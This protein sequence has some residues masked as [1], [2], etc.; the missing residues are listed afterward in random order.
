MVQEQ[1]LSKANW[2]YYC[3][4][5]RRESTTSFQSRW[6]LE[7]DPPN[8]PLFYVPQRKRP[9]FHELLGPTDRRSYQEW[10]DEPNQM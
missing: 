4:D 8:P 9:M 6:R 1:Q 2:R 10:K 5:D 3:D 7:K